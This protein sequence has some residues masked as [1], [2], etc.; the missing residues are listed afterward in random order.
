MNFSDI[1]IGSDKN[2][3]ERLFNCL[4]IN[5][6]TVFESSFKCR[7]GSEF[8]VEVRCTRI[9][10]DGEDV[11]VSCQADVSERKRAEQERVALQTQRLRAQK[12]ET[13][14][15]LAGGLAHDFN[16]ILTPILGLAGLIEATTESTDP[17]HERATEIS[18]ATRQARALVEQI[19]TLG[20]QA[21]IDPE[22]IDLCS[23]L[24]DTLVLVKSSI[25]KDVTL[26]V[27]LPPSPVMI[28]A[29][30]SS[31]HQAFI[32]ESSRPH[33]AFI[34]PSSRSHQAFIKCSSS[35]HQGLI[36][37]PSRPHQAF[38]KCSSRSHQAFISKQVSR[39][40]PSGV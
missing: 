20:S 34:K 8:P 3:L 39:C 4:K 38:I 33:E 10:L 27:E 14:G 1:A 16:N 5:E 40:I 9:Q 24:E 28:Y 30:S 15:R 2:S 36:K 37:C 25:P 17:S 7:G 19:L 6:T 18:V 11:I 13:I 32:N 26:E 21:G 31:V 23:I 12:L 22:V 35:V 29:D